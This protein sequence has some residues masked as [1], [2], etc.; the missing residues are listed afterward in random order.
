MRMSLPCHFKLIDYSEDV[1][2]L[3]LVEVYIINVEG[4]SI[5]M[6]HIAIAVAE[7]LICGAQEGKVRLPTHVPQVVHDLINIF[8]LK[9]AMLPAEERSQIFLYQHFTVVAMQRATVRILPTCIGK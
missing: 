1:V 3:W 5:A 7:Q 9:L 2:L 8:L 4:F 6:A